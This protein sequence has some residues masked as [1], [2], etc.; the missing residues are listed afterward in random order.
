[1]IFPIG[2]HIADLEKLYNDLFCCKRERSSKVDQHVSDF[3]RWG[4]I[5]P[6]ESEPNHSRAE[7]QVRR[8][9]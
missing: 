3:I 5:Q 7:R 8:R 4:F 9:T 2:V 6:S 1:M